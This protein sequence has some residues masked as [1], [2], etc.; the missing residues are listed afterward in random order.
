MLVAAEVKLSLPQ[1]EGVTSQPA[2]VFYD[3]T[4]KKSSKEIL[5]SLG[6]ISLTRILL[7]FDIFI[8]QF[9]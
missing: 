3:S 8:L 2:K 1:G 9:I 4:K 7:F 6:G 5:D